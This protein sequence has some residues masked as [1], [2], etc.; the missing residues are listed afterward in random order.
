MK[1]PR[2][3]AWIPLLAAIV[4]VFGISG[5]AYWY[6]HQKAQVSKGEEVQNLQQE[7]QTQGVPQQALKASSGSDSIINISNWVSLQAE[8]NAYVTIQI[9]PEQKGHMR[10]SMV[11]GTGLSSGASTPVSITTPRGIA[12]QYQSFGDAGCSVERYVKKWTEQPSLK[13]VL[14]T[15]FYCEGETGTYPNEE[16]MLHILDTLSSPDS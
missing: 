4:I 12:W 7:V 1:S 15:V 11:D 8:E 6:E 10:I 3:F 5:A 13:S 9:P 14:V 16:T 2:G